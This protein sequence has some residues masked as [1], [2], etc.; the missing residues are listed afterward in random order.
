MKIPFLNLEIR[1]AKQPRPD[2]WDDFWY[3]N[4]R[5]PSKTGLEI[6]ENEALMTSAIWA[7]VRVISETIASLP[8]HVYRRAGNDGKQRAQD[9]PAYCI[10]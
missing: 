3:E 1:A 7:C 6:T 4:Q 9:H 2:A 10:A 5:Y 8:L